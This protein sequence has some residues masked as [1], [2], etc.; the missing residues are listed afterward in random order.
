MLKLFLWLRYLR[1]RR[2]IFLSIAAVALS[3][4]LLIVVASLFTGFINAFERSAVEMLGDVVIAPPDMPIHGY[5]RLVE[6]LEQMDIVEA[7]TGTLSTQGLLNVGIGNVRPVSVWGIEPDRRAQVTGFQDALVRQRRLSGPPSFDVPEMPEAVGGFVG[8]GVVSQA[9]PNTDEY[10]Q[11]AVLDE[12]LGQRVVIT[13][14]MPSDESDSDRTPRRKLLPFHIADI[15]FTGVH[16]LDTGFVYV[17]IEVLAD[18]LYPGEDAPATTI[19]IRLK[20]GTDPA[21]AVAEIRGLWDVFA[22][23]QLGWSEYLRR[24]ATQ[25]VTAREMQRRYVEEIRKQMGVLLLIFGVVSFTVVVLVFCIFYM[26][27]RLKQRDIAILKSCGAA[28]V[29]VAWIFLG[30][31]MTVG[32]VG[33]AIG[34]VGGYAI[35]KNINAIEEAIRVL[36]GLKLWSSSVYMFAR[37]PNEVDWASAMPIVALAIGAAAIGALTPAIVAALTRPVEVLRYE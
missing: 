2:I 29:S 21:L 24:T 7:A 5:A 8:I 34:A 22:E 4:S 16:D 30:F 10:D 6:R 35:T 15:V 28:S 14:G 13:T 32:V 12:M 33:A 26:I 18:V 36:F 20:P 23:R 11:T 3:V 17:P 25:I 9:D 27:V 31:G 19:N 37:I 1:K